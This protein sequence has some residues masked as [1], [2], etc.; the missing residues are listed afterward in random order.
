MDTV[1]GWR[2]ACA[3]VV[4]VVK[5]VLTEVYLALITCPSDYIHS[6]ATYHSPEFREMFS[7]IWGGSVCGRNFAKLGGVGRNA[8]N[9]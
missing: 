3:V 4:K 5:A 8:K 7:E 9:C 2:D 6:V 1:G